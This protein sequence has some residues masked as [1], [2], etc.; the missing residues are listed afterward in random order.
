MEKHMELHL[1][2]EDC[3]YHN[4]DSV[5]IHL[6]QK[7]LGRKSDI[8]KIYCICFNEAETDRP[9]VELKP[10]MDL[11]GP[12]DETFFDLY[13]RYEPVLHMDRNDYYGGESTSLNL[14]QFMMA[15]GALVRVLIHTSV[16]KYLN[17]K[18]VD[19]SFVYNKGK[20]YKVPATDVEALKSTLMGSLRNAVLESCSFMFKIMMRM[21]PNLMKD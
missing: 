9:E 20:I 11:L 21:I 1:K 12:V 16:A 10:G 8:G 7:Q 13:D 4:S 6:P 18:A 15:N 2:G 3:K 14:V 19:G 17:F 5:Q